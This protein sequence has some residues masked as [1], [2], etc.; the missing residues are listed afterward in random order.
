M[1]LEKLPS[2][3]RTRALFH[4][5]DAGFINRRL[6]H[7]FLIPEARKY[8]ND[9]MNPSD[10]HMARLHND[11]LLTT[12]VIDIC[13]A[14]GVPTLWQVISD[15]KNQSM[16]RGDYRLTPCPGVYEKNSRVSHEVVHD[17]GVDKPIVIEYGTE[18]LVSSTG[19][20]VLSEGHKK[21]YVQ[22]IVGICYDEGARYR[23]DPMI[24]GNPWLDHP[25]NTDP[26]GHLMWFG[27]SHG[28]LLPEDI[29][30][31]ARMKDVPQP[32]ANT[33]MSAMRALPEAQVKEAFASLLGDPTKK[34]WGGELNDH[35]SASVTVAGSRRTAA[36]LLKGPARFAEMTPNMCG[37]KADQIFRL[38]NSRADIAV[39]Q[40]CHLVGEAV[41][42]TLRALAVFPGNPGMYCVIDGP[43]TFRILRAYGLV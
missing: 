28:E 40:H 8:Y 4:H 20:M 32:D 21:G 19:T 15:R 14:I 6:C 16:F 22:S 33:W 43:S 11:H 35:F 41:R 24:M 23:I 29:E 38:V 7:Q 37:S 17:V 18:H 27:R 2:E 34:D 26:T 10:H 13:D 31:F 39:L 36:F 25:R 5:I 9:L 3:D 30:Q 42:H 12:M 1:T